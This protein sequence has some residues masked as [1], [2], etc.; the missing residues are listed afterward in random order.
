MNR[1]DFIKITSL[2]IAG[3]VVPVEIIHSDFSDSEKSEKSEKSENLKPDFFTPN[4]KFYVTSIGSPPTINLDSWRLRIGGLVQKPMAFSYQE[5]TAF[6]NVATSRT[7][8]CI[9]NPIGGDQISN[10]KWT[11]VRLKEV[12][13]KVGLKPGVVK[14]IFRCADGYHTAIPVADALNENAVLA[15][16]MNEATL[17][18]EHGYPLRFLNPGHYGMK[19]PKW[20][21]NLEPTNK[22][23][24]GYWEKQSWSDEAKVKLL[25]QIKTPSDGEKI[26]IDER[27]YVISGLAFDG[28]NGGG[29][30]MVEVSTDAGKSWQQAEIWKSDSPLAWSLWKYRWTPPQTSEKSEKEVSFTIKVRATNKFGAIQNEKPISAYPDG[31]SGTHTIKIKVGSDG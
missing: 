10:A 11:G 24:I 12:L 22:D 20:I 28:G 25:S 13:E 19:C 2:S 27:V 15:F 3:T 31:A 1:R 9:G 8:M 23:H 30:A 26:K 16:K 7:L 14:V 18:A 17:P 6:E 5:I 4:D 29:I 21:I